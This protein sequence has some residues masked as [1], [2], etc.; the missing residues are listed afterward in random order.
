MPKRFIW[1]VACAGGVSVELTSQLFVA[2]EAKRQLRNLGKMN[3]AVPK[4]REDIMAVKFHVCWRRAGEGRGKTMLDHSRRNTTLFDVYTTASYG[5]RITH[6]DL[7]ICNMRFLPSSPR[8]FPSCQIKG[9]SG[10]REHGPNPHHRIISDDNKKCVVDNIK[11][12]VLS[13]IMGVI[14]TA[15]KYYDH[16]PNTI[17]SFNYIMELELDNTKGSQ[18]SYHVFLSHEK[19]FMEAL[20]PSSTPHPSPPLAPP[21]MPF[22]DPDFCSGN[23]DLPEDVDE[24]IRLGEI[25]ARERANQKKRKRG[26]CVIL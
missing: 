14:M 23:K 6:P 18:T 15:R 17:P 7:I 16:F 25:L 21:S 10:D 22:N 4:H 1:H 12:I 26:Y 8:I 11:F 13:A 24:F 3:L 19:V 2:A 9:S 20:N 5:K